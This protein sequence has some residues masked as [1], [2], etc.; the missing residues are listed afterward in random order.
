MV[1]SDITLYLLHPRHL[2]LSS[3]VTH[4]PHFER[5][6][7]LRNCTYINNRYCQNYVFFVHFLKPFEMLPRAFLFSELQCSGNR[8]K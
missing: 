4:V 5:N 7:I 1:I 3:T 6:E 8:P 2:L